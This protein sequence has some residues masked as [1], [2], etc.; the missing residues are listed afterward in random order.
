MRDLDSIL[1]ASPVIPVLVVDRVEDAVPIAEAL[2]AG[3][4]P[5]L[6]VTLRT[7]AAL[8]VIRAMRSVQGAIVGA[9][10]I[11]N[12]HGLEKAVAAGAEFAVSPGLTEALG[13]AAAESPVP[14]LPGVANAS[15]IMRALDLGFA[16]LKFFPAAA[17]G[18]L[19]ALKGFSA[20]FGSVRFCPTGGI[21]LETAPDWLAIPSVACV[22]GS[23]LVPSGEALDPARIRERARAA[24]RLRPAP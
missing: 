22:G 1:A 18:G 19:A 17:S 5:V 16:R 4:L 21:S 23:W 12:A 14:L 2:V 8:D 9:G 10:T 11:L 20:V 6:E 13:R 3:G 24:A 7:P 15:D